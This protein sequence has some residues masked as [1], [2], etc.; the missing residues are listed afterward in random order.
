MD[1]GFDRVK[2]W[3]RTYG[4]RKEDGWWFVPSRHAHSRLRV[5]ARWE[6]E[7]EDWMED[8]RGG[9]HF[10]VDWDGDMTQSRVDVIR[11]EMTIIGQLYGLTGWKRWREVCADDAVWF[12]VSSLE[13]WKMVR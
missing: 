11:A 10:A 3:L 8:G 2:T 5:V 13:Y 12:F 4:R 1:L 7:D 6:L 9:L